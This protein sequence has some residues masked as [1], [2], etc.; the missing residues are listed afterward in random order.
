MHPDLIRQLIAQGENNRLEF[1][2]AQ[3][4]PEAI[5]REIVAFANTLGGTLLLGVA[6]DGAIMGVESEGVTG[7]HV[8]ER[9]ANILRHNIVP[10]LGVE[11]SPVEM[12]GKTLL[13]IAVPKGRD[14]PYQT[15]DGKYWIR[16]GSTN[17]MATKEELSRLFQQAGLVHFDISPV[18][19]TGVKDLDLDAIGN[20]YRTYYDIDFAALEEAE[21]LNILD[22]ADILIEHEGERTVSV[23]GMLL[24]GRQPQRRLPQSAVSFALF[25]GDMLT[26]ELLDK[27]ELTGTL[28]TLIDNT[29]A[30]IKLFIPVA[31]S[32]EGT[33]RV[34]TVPIPGKVLREAVVNALAHRDYSIGHRKTM[35]QLFDNRLEITSPGGLPNTLT[36]DKIRHG[37]SAPRNIFLV[38]Y[39]DNL[40][41]FDGLGRGIPMMCKAM[42]ERIVLEEIGQLFRV[43]L[44]PSQ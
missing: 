37:N 7:R 41:Y 12:A 17:R 42:G 14:K 36:V 1:K 11:V 16:A 2:S 31:S 21:R 32:T 4:R 30:L 19:D 22:N 10:A 26:D 18:V 5:A 15:I 6:D 13:A 39:L 24:F 40:R 33:R 25:R 38:K 20:Y 27:K 3:A 44:Y 9:L 8:E 43:T 29:V 35:V 23:G 34:E 28:P